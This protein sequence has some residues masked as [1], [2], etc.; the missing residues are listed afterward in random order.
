LYC[1]NINILAAWSI[2]STRRCGSKRYH[3]GEL[4]QRWGIDFD[5]PFFSLLSM[6]LTGC[7]ATPVREI[8]MQ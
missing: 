4:D 2:R 7:D 8:A 3:R 1:I 5:D 6:K